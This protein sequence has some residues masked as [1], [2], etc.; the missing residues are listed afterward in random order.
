VRAPS[1]ASFGSGYQSPFCLLR[2]LSRA[3]ERGPKTLHPGVAGR[4]DAGPRLRVGEQP[5][6]LRKQHLGRGLLLLELLDPAEPLEHL[7]RLVHP[8]DGTRGCDTRM[9]GLCAE[10]R[11]DAKQYLRA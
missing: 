2:P 3:V 8:A 4:L 6:Q 9:T 1:G 7:L 10:L 5:A 11:A